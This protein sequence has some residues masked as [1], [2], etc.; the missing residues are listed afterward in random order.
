MHSS[1]I[2]ALHRMARASN[3]S[4]FVKNAPSAA[5]TGLNGRGLYVL[6]H[7]QSTGEGMTYARH[8]ARAL[9]A[10]VLKDS[11]RIV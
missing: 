4:I 8:F 6:D 11:F 1:N 9:G 5:G 10:C 7:R 2:H 3:T